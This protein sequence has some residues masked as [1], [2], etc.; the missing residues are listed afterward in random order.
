[1]IH[2]IKDDQLDSLMHEMVKCVR[3]LADATASWERDRKQENWRRMDRAN[4]AFTRVR[5]E[6]TKAVN[7]KL[8]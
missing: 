4:V 3:E 7:E 6:F 8:P 2:R 5:E 1:M